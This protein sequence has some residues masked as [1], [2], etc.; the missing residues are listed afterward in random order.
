MCYIIDLAII[1]YENKVGDIAQLGEACLPSMDK[2]LGL[3]PSSMDSN[4]Q[5]QSKPVILAFRK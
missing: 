3:I 5:W 2:A 1:K 4:Q